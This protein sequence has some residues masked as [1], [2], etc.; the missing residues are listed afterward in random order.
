[1]FAHTT[2]L[3]SIAGLVLLAAPATAVV[4]ASADT[5]PALQAR[6]GISIS[7]ACHMQYADQICTAATKGNNCDDWVCAC[8]NGEHGLNLDAYCVA[9]HNG[10]WYATCHNG[11]YNWQC[12]SR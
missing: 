1:M 6:D 7:E 4:V 3:G 12:V 2:I 11:V 10:N 9:K 8:N 5:T